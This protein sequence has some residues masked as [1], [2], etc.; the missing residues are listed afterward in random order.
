[1]EK[2]DP[3]SAEQSVT[4]DTVEM[5]SNQDKSKKYTRFHERRWS[6]FK[7]YKKSLLE[8]NPLEQV[9]NT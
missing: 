7:V 3:R 5:V 6:G 8:Y 4:S 2:V 9:Y 1:M